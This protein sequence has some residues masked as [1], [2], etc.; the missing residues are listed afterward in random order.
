MRDQVP[1]VGAVATVRNRRGVIAGVEPY[2][3]DRG[4]LH[5]VHLE[6]K[7]DQL[8]EQ[9]IWELEPRTTVLEPTE[10]PPVAQATRCPPSDLAGSPHVSWGPSRTLGANLLVREVIQ[11]DF[12]D[13]QRIRRSNPNIVIDH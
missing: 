3:G 4:R 1:R 11:V 5:L 7:D 2:D 10:L 13:L 12:L 6:Y 8:D 9:L